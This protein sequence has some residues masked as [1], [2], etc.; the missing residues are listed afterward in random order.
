MVSVNGQTT[1]SGLTYT[2]VNP[3]RAVD[4]RE[5]AG[6]GT[7]AFSGGNF[8]QSSKRKYTL[9]AAPGCAG[10]IPS[11]ARAVAVNATVVPRA[12]FSIAPVD[13]VLLWQ[14]D[15]T[16]NPNV[17]SAA[18]VR[19]PAGIV[20]ATFA[21]VPMDVYGA[22]WA[23]TS[24]ETHLVLD[25]SGYYSDNSSGLAFYAIPPC[26]VIDT[27]ETGG[28]ALSVVSGSD[29]AWLG[30]AGSCGAPSV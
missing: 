7:G 6:T 26:R 9:P 15:G 29:R 18:T 22:I 8:T 16:S 2:P 13:R 27:R 14:G 4:T 30:L 11:S 23:Y 5:P 21:T 20:V 28:H 1:F 25:I 10:Q 3:C 19:N 24:D 17:P 12:N